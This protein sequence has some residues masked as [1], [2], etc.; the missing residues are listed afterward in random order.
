MC[1]TGGGS[2]NTDR[3]TQIREAIDELAAQCQPGGAPGNGGPALPAA[4]VSARLA[5][6]WAMLSE[7]DTELARRLPGYGFPP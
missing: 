1:S 7:L 6:I 2:V 3:L 5:R 4:D